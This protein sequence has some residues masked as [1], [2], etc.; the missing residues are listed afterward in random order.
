LGASQSGA[1]K[2]ARCDVTDQQILVAELIGDKLVLSKSHK[3]EFRDIDGDQIPEI[4]H[5]DGGRG[6]Q[7]LDIYSI[8]QGRTDLIGSFA[9]GGIDAGAN[10][11]FFN[12]FLV[13]EKG[14]LHLDAQP[15]ACSH[16]DDKKLCAEQ[17]AEARKAAK[18]SKFLKFDPGLPPLPF[19]G[20]LE[21][22]KFVQVKN[23]DG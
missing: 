1:D 20:K 15:Y 4:I 21:G 3:G 16:S 22:G 10:A 11:D 5:A 23:D 8:K 13:D 7:S 2:A 19:K 12:E 18:T 14:Y 6:Y 9:S 17:L